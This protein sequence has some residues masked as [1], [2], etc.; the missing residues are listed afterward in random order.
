[1]LKLQYFDHLLWRAN[2]LAMTLIMGNTEGKRRRGWQ[3]TKWLYLTITDLMMSLN[4]LQEM[5]KDRKDWCAAGHSV[6]KSQT[7]LNDRTSTW[8]GSLS[9]CC[10]LRGQPPSIHKVGQKSVQNGSAGMVDSNQHRLCEFRLK[11][12]PDVKLSLTKDGVHIQTREILPSLE[13]TQ[14]NESYPTCFNRA[15]WSTQ[16]RNRNVLLILPL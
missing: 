15:V 10:T 2:S 14:G 3:R 8:P 9:D 16:P 6:A 12:R 13:R 11:L 4:K 7:W 1:M 5:V